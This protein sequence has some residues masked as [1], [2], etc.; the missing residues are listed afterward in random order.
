ML[1]PNSYVDEVLLKIL[2]TRIENVNPLL[3]AI[4]VPF[5]GNL[6]ASL[7]CAQ[8]IKKNHPTIKIAMGGGFPNTE[9]RSLSDVRVFEFFDFITLDDGEAPIENLI[10]YLQNKI[11]V[12]SL[13]RCFTMVEGKLLYINNA[14]CIDYKQGQVGTP[15]YSDFLLDQYISA[16]EIVNPMHSLWSNGRW[17]KLTMAHGCYWGKC[18]FCD[19]SLDYIKLYEPITASLLC[20]RMEEMI[21]QTGENG[22]HFVDEAAPPAIMRSLALEIIKRKL[23]VDPHSPPNFRVDG[24]LPHIDDFYDEFKIK[25]TDSL[26]IKYNLRVKIFSD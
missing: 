8:W 26:Y 3:V 7:R 12:T 2:K 18:T 24:V 16:I 21:A 23:I 5:P 13:K 10:H 6:Y 15:D 20:D 25:K 1:Q 19:V 11:P 17:N 22:F 14:A 9:L 4:S